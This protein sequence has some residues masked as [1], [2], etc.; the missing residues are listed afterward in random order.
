MALF[1]T[2]PRRDE[3][4]I[5]RGLPSGPRLDEERIGR[6]KMGSKPKAGSGISKLKTVFLYNIKSTCSF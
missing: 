2:R 3:V 1:V 6:G 4:R 5:D